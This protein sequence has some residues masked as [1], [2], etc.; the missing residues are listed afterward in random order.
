MKLN[1]S[2]IWAFVILLLVAALYRSWDGRPFGFAPQMAMALFGGAVIS[3]KR[4]AVL[5]PILSLFL[6]DVV[7]QILYMNGLSSIQGFYEGQ[8]IIYVLFVGITFF[9]MLMK[10]IDLKNVLGFTISGSLIFF[11][12]SNFAVWA[13]GGGLG[14]PKTFN[15]LILCYEDAIIFYR[16][17]GLIKGFAGNHIIGDLFFSFLLFGV[18]VLA[19]NY[20]IRPAVKTA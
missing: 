9:G 13:G 14:R 6:S 3:D 7:Y 8:W 19:K 4:F 10:K 5:L 1:K 17:Y 16:D 2:T 18:F 20:F 12:L 15:G 11:L